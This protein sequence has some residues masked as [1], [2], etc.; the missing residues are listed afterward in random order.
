MKIC[1]EVHLDLYRVLVF[2]ARDEGSEDLLKLRL[3]LRVLAQVAMRGS[4]P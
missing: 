1:G 4:I 3:R 2:L